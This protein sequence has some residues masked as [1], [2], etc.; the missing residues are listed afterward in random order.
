M[1]LQLNNN[2]TFNL[3]QREMFAKLL[4]QAKAQVQTELESEYAINQR[5]EEELTPKFVEEYGVTK[6]IEDIRKLRKNLTDQETALSDLGFSC[7]ED[8]ISIRSSAPKALH[9]TLESAQR[10]AKRERDQVLKKYDLA[11][12]KVW[13]LED[14]QEA[15]KIVEGL[16]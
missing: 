16:L 3:K 10:S 6:L 15:R 12:L 8:E 1:E 9:E 4:V 13:A 2:H 14:A 5:I 7:T 11:I